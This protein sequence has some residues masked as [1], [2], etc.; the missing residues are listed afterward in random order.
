MQLF[1]SCNSIYNSTA[2]LFTCEIEFQNSKIFIEFLIA[3]R[4]NDIYTI[5]QVKTNIFVN[6]SNA[7]LHIWPVMIFQ[8]FLKKKLL[9]II[10]KKFIISFCH[11]Y[12]NP[13]LLLWYMDMMI[14]YYAIWTMYAHDSIIL[15]C[16]N[17]MHIIS[18]YYHVW[19]ILTWY[20]D[21]WTICTWYYEI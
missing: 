11:P 16:I 13:L 6:T 20:Y 8:V 3:K 1:H 18:W 4:V 12:W 7:R 17:Y 21:E 10:T 19:T 9:K 14:W 5:L 15:W 2:L